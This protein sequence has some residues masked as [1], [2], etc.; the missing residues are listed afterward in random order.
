MEALLVLQIIIVVLMVCVILMQRS[1][2]DGFTGGSSTAGGL[3]SGRSQANLL[4]KTTS[5][6]AAIFIINSLTLAYIASHTQRESSLS[7]KI[8]QVE[9]E[10]NN[11]AKDESGKVDLAPESIDTTIPTVPLG[12]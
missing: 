9:E 2:N 6:L 8:I 5:I 1:S 7:E 12:E 3:M 10:E 11:K 4:T